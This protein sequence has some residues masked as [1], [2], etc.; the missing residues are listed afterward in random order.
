MLRSVVVKNC[1]IGEAT[2]ATH[3]DAINRLLSKLWVLFPDYDRRDVPLL[4]YH[5]APRTHLNILSNASRLLHN[6]AGTLV[7]SGFDEGSVTLLAWPNLTVLSQLPKLV[8]IT[9]GQSPIPYYGVW[10]SRAIALSYLASAD[11]LHDVV[12][13]KYVVL[14]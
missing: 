3:V 1:H 4:F 6:V 7:V 2:V 12:L 11:S 9:P 13:W 5:S 8:L 14:A 10:T